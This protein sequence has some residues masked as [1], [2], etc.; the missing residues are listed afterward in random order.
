MQPRKILQID[1]YARFKAALCYR[2]DPLVEVVR[3]VLAHFFKIQL[4]IDDK[5][6]EDATLEAENGAVV[7]VFEIKGVNGS[8]TRA[9]INQVDS[10]R[11][12]LGV[13]PDTPGILIMNTMMSANSLAMKDEES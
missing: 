5:C 13:S 9:N 7:A 2:S 6:V 11:E 10:H 1:S 4:T 12:R 8:F 3:D